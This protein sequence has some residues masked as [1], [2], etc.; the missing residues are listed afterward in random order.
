MK[1]HL[2]TVGTLVLACSLQ[3]QITTFVEEPEQ[4]QGALDF[5][6]AQGWGN[7]PDLND[8][9][10]AVSGTAI[11]MQ[12]ADGSWGCQTPSNAGDIAGKI[13]VVRRGGPPGQLPCEFGLKA[14]NA[15]NAGAIAVVIVN[16]APGAPV[17]MGG[18]SSGGDVAIPVVMITDAAGALLDSE[19]SAGNVV[20]FIGSLTG[21]FP[22]NLGMERRH[23]LQPPSTGTSDLLA[24]N[25]SEL[26]VPLGAWV[27]NYGSQTDNTSR[28]RCI[29]SQGGTEIYNEVS[30]DASIVPGD[31]A[32]F[33]LPTFSQSSYGGHYTITYTAESDEEDGFIQNNLIGTSLHVGDVFTYAGTDPGTGIPVATQ[34]VLGADAT[35]MTTC[36]YF[37]NPNA[38]RVAATGMYVASFAGAPEVITDRLVEVTAYLWTDVI[39]GP[40]T[41]PTPQ[42]LAVLGTGEYFFEEG[43]QGNT[44][45]IPFTEPIALDPGDNYLF[46]MESYDEVLRHG[47]DNLT[48]YDQH[49]ELYEQPISMIRISGSW[50]NGFTNLGGPPS[51]GVQLIDANSIGINELDRVDITPYPNPASDVIMIPLVGQTGAATLQIFDLAG[52]KVAEQRVSMGGND[53]LT[54][55]VNG[56]SNGA[57]VFQMNFENGQFSTFRVVVSR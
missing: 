19:I 52:A 24:T 3:A 32:W 40:L 48:D 51:I 10:E 43:D 16:N 29:I 54:V 8:P 41:L 6:W 42:G 18:G 35:D 56:I 44:V 27:I 21:Q 20:L 2:L 11:W 5:S 15:Q 47:W 38:N 25:A 23:V 31:S 1:Q 12:D 13:A 50:Y 7:L 33:T 39:A 37:A 22:Y 55:S 30:T 26:S 57:Y 34:F 14:L 46:C 4:L 28:L 36:I 49:T 17:A 45:F 53:L 9:A